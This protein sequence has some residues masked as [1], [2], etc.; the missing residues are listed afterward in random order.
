MSLFKIKGESVQLIPA[1]V[2][3][4]YYKDDK[5]E[6]TFYI[7]ALILD[8]YS[9]ERVVNAR[10]LFVNTKHPPLD[11]E[12]VLLLSTISSYASGLGYNEDLYYLGIIN[13]Q[14]NVHHNSLPNVNEITVQS[15]AGGSAEG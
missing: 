5:P 6:S 7:K 8:G 15:N 3:E 4:V 11:G 13:L 12:T 9:S 2:K 10:P 14:G 1:K